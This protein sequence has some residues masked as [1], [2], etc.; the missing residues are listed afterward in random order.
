LAKD[1]FQISNFE[2][3]L[4]VGFKNDKIE[5]DFTTFCDKIEPYKNDILWLEI[6]SSI[7]LLKRIYPHK[8]KT[9]IIQM[10]KDKRYELS[11]MSTK[12]EKILDGIDGWLI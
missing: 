12:I 6:S 7:H 1:A 4:P 8:T 9:E 10:I 11:T 5:S 3:V 2:S